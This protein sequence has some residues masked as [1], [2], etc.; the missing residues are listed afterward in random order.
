MNMRIDSVLN[1]EAVGFFKTL[2]INYPTTRCNNPEDQV[3]QQSVKTP[4][5][6]LCIFEIILCFVFIVSFSCAIELL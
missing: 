3:L 1:R 4:N 2:E 5:H 6:D